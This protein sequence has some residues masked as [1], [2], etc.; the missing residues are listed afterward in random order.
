L[1]SHGPRTGPTG[2]AEGRNATRAWSSRTLPCAW[3]SSAVDRLVLPGA[4]PWLRALV[5][6][7]SDTHTRRKREAAVHLFRW[8]DPARRADRGRAPGTRALRG[9]ILRKPRRAAGQTAIAHG[10]RE[11]PRPRPDA[12]LARAAGSARRADTGVRTHPALARRTPR[13][14]CP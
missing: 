1:T 14:L 7:P 12:V 11:R 9:A 3:R 13:G 6:P 4:H 5:S 2:N 8:Q 10:D